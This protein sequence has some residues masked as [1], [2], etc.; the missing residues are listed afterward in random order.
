M[1]T[2][3]FLQPISQ[4]KLGPLQKGPLYLP[5]L[6]TQEL[7]NRAG[8]GSQPTTWEGVGKGKNPLK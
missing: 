3:S 2:A 7:A 5:W 8:V 6:R 4:N 1:G